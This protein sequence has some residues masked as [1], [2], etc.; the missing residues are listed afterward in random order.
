[1]AIEIIKA[2]GKKVPFQADKLQRSLLKA[3]AD[4]GLA[5]E[6]V[7]EVSSRLFPGVS[8]RRIHQLAFRMLRQHQSHLAAKYDLKKAMLEMG[9]SGFP[10][11]IYTGELFKA[12]GCLVRLDQMM[13]GFCVRHE[14]DV[15]ARAGSRLHIMECKYHNQRGL[16]C[17]V[18]IPLYIHAR[19][20]D[21]ARKSDP[22]LQ[23]Q[24]WV[25]TNTKFSEDAT[26]YGT[27]AGLRL[28]SWNYPAN[29]GLGE[30][31]D[32]SGL[33]PLTCL[34]TLSRK[35]KSSL[36]DKKIVLSSQIASNPGLLREAGIGPEAQPKIL[37]E[38]RKLCPIKDA[39]HSDISGLLPVL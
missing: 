20:Q 1:M 5:G 27:C 30:I 23:L 18:K 13:E 26:T 32:T 9:P 4:P 3:G 29:R 10:F 38:I 35:E 16:I 24:G 28:L 15:I 39:S 21:T 7:A 36:L 25:I 22:A 34:T 31:I 8:T 11:E 12:A 14:V 2:S 37:E 6:I 17:D 19:F 33:Y